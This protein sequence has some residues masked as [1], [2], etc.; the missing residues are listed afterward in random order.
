MSS[1]P[2]AACTAPLSG[3]VVT[4]DEIRAEAKTLEGQA[5]NAA[6][7]PLVGSLND[8]GKELVIKA[9]FMVAMSD[10]EFPDEEKALMADI[11]KAL[12]ISNKRFQEILGSLMQEQPPQQAQAG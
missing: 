5:L 4:E 1:R 10:G 9:A 11:A 8:A 3:A 7:S 12:E 6:I 2:S